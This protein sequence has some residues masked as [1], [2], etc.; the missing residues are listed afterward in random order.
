MDSLDTF[1]NS[2]MNIDLVTS[3]LIG[4]ETKM[5]NVIMNQSINS[6][7]ILMNTEDTAKMSIMTI[8]KSNSVVHNTLF[9]RGQNAN[10]PEHRNISVVD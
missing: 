4:I 1:M 2:S 3:I 6:Q 5:G 7:S 8:K 10:S 9:R